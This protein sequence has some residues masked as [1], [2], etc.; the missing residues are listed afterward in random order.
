MDWKNILPQLYRSRIDT[1]FV[2]HSEQF[3]VGASK[4]G[5]PARC[6]GRFRLAGI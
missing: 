3:A 1:R 5:G 2:S 6:A 4:F